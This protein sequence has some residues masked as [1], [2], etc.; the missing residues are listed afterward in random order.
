ME[1]V[2]VKT[3]IVGA[4]VIGLAIGAEI[5][6]RGGQAFILESGR[7]FG[8]GISSRNSEVIHS[9]IYYPEK[10]LKS[11]FCVEGREPL[12]AYCDRHGVSYRKC[13]KLIVAASDSEVPKIESI[14]LQAQ[15]NGAETGELIDGKAARK[16]E[17]A[18]AAVAALHVPDT[19]IIDSHAYMSCLSAEIESAGGAI[20][21]HHKVL[22]G[23]CGDKNFELDVETPSG[24]LSVKTDQLV[25]SAGLGSHHLADRLEGYGVLGV[26]SLTL[27]K[28]SYFSCSGGTVFTRLIYPAPVDG[29]LGTHLTLDLAGRMRFGPDV[30]WLESNDP[31]QID[32]VVDAARSIAFYDSI[33]RY[34]PSL[35][36]GALI[37]DYSGVRPKLSRQGEAAVD[38]LLHGPEAHGIA[39]LVALYGIESPGLTSSLAMARHVVGMLG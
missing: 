21:L 35:P 23:R 5:A 18:L 33:R 3:I 22:G 31:E 2:E 13:G 16:L 10:S 1:V 4:G 17:P 38:F 27:A 15:R 7:T 36:D 9:G 32:F 39:G 24:P 6:R 28:G 11:R 30:E 8:S 26:P 34:W 25:L 29:G 19:G 37:P 14:A 20:L 12:Y